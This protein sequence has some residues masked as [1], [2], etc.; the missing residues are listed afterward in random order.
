MCEPSAA[1]CQM[2]QVSLQREF[3]LSLLILKSWSMFCAAHPCIAALV[4]T[5]RH[6]G[7]VCSGGAFFALSMIGNAGGG[8]VL[9]MSPAAAGASAG[10]VTQVSCLPVLLM[11]Q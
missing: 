9:G 1:A 2:K 8:T 5:S 11:L 3:A 7:H 4:W 10:A 6:G